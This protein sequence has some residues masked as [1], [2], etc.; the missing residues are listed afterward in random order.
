MFITLY[1]SYFIELKDS[2]T[3]MAAD[4]ALGDDNSQSVGENGMNY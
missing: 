3:C 1:A 2:E 4:L